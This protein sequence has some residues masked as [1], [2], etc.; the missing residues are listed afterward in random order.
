MAPRSVRACVSRPQRTAGDFG[1]ALTPCG[2]KISLILS[3]F[4]RTNDYDSSPVGTEVV[5]VT[6]SITSAALVSPGEFHVPGEIKMINKSTEVHA[7]MAHAKGGV[8]SYSSN[9]TL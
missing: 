5:Q 8:F 1:Y 7:P 3:K 6:F 4:P 9:S 2:S